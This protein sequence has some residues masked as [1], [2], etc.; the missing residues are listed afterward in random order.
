MGLTS[1][2]YFPHLV[3]D[4]ARKPLYSTSAGHPF[5]SHCSALVAQLFSFNFGLYLV[6][7]S[8]QYLC[9]SL[10]TRG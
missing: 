6:E 1:G 9:T 2:Y 7:C 5:Q 4:L 10:E 3:E 8:M